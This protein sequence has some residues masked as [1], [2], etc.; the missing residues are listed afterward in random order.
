MGQKR[1]QS[2][3]QQQQPKHGRESS[4]CHG[5]TG[6]QA[7]CE[8]KPSGQYLILRLHSIQQRD[9]PNSCKP[10]HLPPLPSTP[11]HLCPPASHF[12][13]STSAPSPRQRN[14]STAIINVS[15]DITRDFQR[16]DTVRWR[17]EPSLATAR[18]GELHRRNDRCSGDDSNS[19]KQIK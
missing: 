17:G 14:H 1:P 19:G 3:Q 2:H 10:P 4:C 8:K 15:P 6:I 5:F 9:A 16:I 12:P 13:F 18:Y 11:P 7:C